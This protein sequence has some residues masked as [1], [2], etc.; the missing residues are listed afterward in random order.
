[1]ILF[2]DLY[3]DTQFGLGMQNGLISYLQKPHFVERIGSVRYQFSQKHFGIRVQ[4]VND[5]VEKL[6]H[7][8]LVFEF[9]HGSIC[10]F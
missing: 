6:L 5:Q 4:G 3:P 1:M 10:C 7:L 8:R 9:L 2:I